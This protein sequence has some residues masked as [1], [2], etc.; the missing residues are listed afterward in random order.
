MSERITYRIAEKFLASIRELSDKELNMAL[1]DAR[2]YT[3]TNCWW[4]AFRLQTALIEVMENE[5]KLRDE[6]AKAEASK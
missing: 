1:A 3:T 6:N 2:S 4:V 5:M